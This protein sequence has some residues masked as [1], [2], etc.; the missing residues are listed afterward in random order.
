HARFGWQRCLGRMG[1]TRSAHLGKCATQRAA[2]SSWFS[3]AA[4]S[5]AC[6]W[7]QAEE[8]D[9]LDGENAISNRATNA[10]T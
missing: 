8:A 10:Q 9:S 2:A 5:S 7:A 1:V 4:L 6:P 3:Q